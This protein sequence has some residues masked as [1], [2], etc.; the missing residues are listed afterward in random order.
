M[1]EILCPS[2][3]K[4]SGLLNTTSKTHQKVNDPLHNVLKL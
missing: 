1:E 4:K 3:P 2:T